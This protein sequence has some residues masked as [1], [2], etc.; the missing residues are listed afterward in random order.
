MFDDGFINGD[1]LIHRFDPRFKIV[2]AVAFSIVVAVSTR[3]V[4]LIPA[5][6]LSLVLVLAGRL[7]IKK[8]CFRLMVVNGL[9]LFLWFFLPFSFE[10]APFFTIG[11][12]TATE[13]GVRYATILTLRSNIIILALISLVSTISVFTFG[14]AMR[15]L[16]VPDKIVQ[17]FFFTYRYLHVI[18]LEYER[19]VKALKI[20]GFQ[21]K[22][23]MHTYK[24]YAYLVGMLLVKSYDRSER[25]RRAMLCR[26]FKGS[27]YDLSEFR[28][29]REDIVI[30]FLMLMAV[31]A[32][33]L[34]QWTTIIY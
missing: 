16:R 21:P 13:E 7:P 10:G 3:W 6:F 4:A 28:V 29:R 12:F 1:S 34:L 5:L 9:I 24:T 17:L 15:E 8:A 26:G 11:P 25:V 27:F 22:T 23:N 19:L 30:M 20:R 2:V 14:R 18:H 32:I 33:A 31:A